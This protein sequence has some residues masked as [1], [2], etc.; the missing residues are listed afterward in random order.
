MMTR[1]QLSMYCQPYYPDHVDGDT[2]VN[3]GDMYTM[4]GRVHR[5][6]EVI[7]SWHMMWNQAD[8]KIKPWKVYDTRYMNGLLTRLVEWQNALRAKYVRLTTDLL[9]GVSSCVLDIKVDEEEQGTYFTQIRL[10]RYDQTVALSLD[11]EYMPPVKD[12]MLELA[13]IENI[14]QRKKQ[15][16][17]EGLKL[18]RLWTRLRWV[19]EHVEW[20]QKMLLIAITKKLE[21]SA[22][23]GMVAVV[24]IDASTYYLSYELMSNGWRMIGMDLPG[25]V[26]A[27]QLDLTEQP[28]PYSL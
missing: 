20:V 5:N 28:E 9:N 16:G 22:K 4:D 18:Y 7:A 26:G 13:R 11:S 12:L 8:W 14:T 6:G 21:R 15:I 3:D 10:R 17:R 23:T 24:K 27:M 1:T 2:K 19:A 25:R